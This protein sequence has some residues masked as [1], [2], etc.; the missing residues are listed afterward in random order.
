MEYFMA[1]HKAAL[2]GAALLGIVSRQICPSSGSA[3]GENGLNTV[4][5]QC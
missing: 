3:M 1:K 2:F 4:A 5:I